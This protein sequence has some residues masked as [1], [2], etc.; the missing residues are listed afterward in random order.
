MF[1]LIFVQVRSF[2]S[3]CWRSLTLCIKRMFSIKTGPHVHQVKRAMSTSAID[4]ARNIIITSSTGV[5]T[6]VVGTLHYHTPYTHIDHNYINVMSSEVIYCQFKATVETTLFKF[7]EE[8]SLPYYQCID[9]INTLPYYLH[10]HQIT[11]E[12]ILYR[13]L[14]GILD[15]R[16]V[17]FIR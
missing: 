10:I 12:S 7:Y 8:N 4:H 17:I 3:H 5:D 1:Q 9:R 14:A 16:A 13:I 2:A 11:Q 15:K 6:L